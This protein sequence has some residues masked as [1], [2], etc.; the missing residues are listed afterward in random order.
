M[1]VG[2]M[3]VEGIGVYLL[4]VSAQDICDQNIIKLV[5]VRQW[6]RMGLNLEQL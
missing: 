6:D 3:T 5:V 2:D 1:D 4:P